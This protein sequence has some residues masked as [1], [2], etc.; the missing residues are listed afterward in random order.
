LAT[1]LAD[2]TGDVT[3]ASAIAAIEAMPE[4]DLP[5]GAGMTY[6]CGGSAIESMPAVCSNQW[7]RTTLD[8]DGQP[9][10]YEPVDSSEILDGL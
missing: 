8:A 3:P 6:Q 10:D 7:L 9:T 5:G 4:S 1:A 2:V